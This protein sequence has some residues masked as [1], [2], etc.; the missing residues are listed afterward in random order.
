MTDLLVIILQKL[1]NDC[2]SGIVRINGYYNNLIKNLDDKL[3]EIILDIGAFSGPPG[4]VPVLIPP[5]RD[6]YGNIII[7]DINPNTNQRRFRATSYPKLFIVHP[8]PNFGL[9]LNK[10]VIPPEQTQS[11]IIQ[12][13]QSKINDAKT[14]SGITLSPD[15]RNSLTTLINQLNLI[16]PLIEAAFDIFVQTIPAKGETLTYNQPEVSI[17][18]KWYFTLIPGLADYQQKQLPL[19]ASN[20]AAVYANYYRYVAMML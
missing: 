15:A 4:S 9:I 3:F 14:A 1:I 5:L 18:F 16:Q 17:P 20:M 10:F 8:P 11:G 2:N 13:I 12:K 19:N 6:T 7:P